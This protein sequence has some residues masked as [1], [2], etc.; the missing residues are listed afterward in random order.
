MQ[1]PVCGGFL[2]ARDVFFSCFF[3][4]VEPHSF[5]SL[6]R[7]PSALL[8]SRR[9]PWV[10]VFDLCVA[11]TIGLYLCCSCSLVAVCV[12]SSYAVDRGGPF[13]GS[14]SFLLLV[15]S[16][17]VPGEGGFPCAQVVVGCGGL[18]F[19][20]VQGCFEAL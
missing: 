7:Y 19:S 16:S 17:W 8:D 13:A 18:T 20:A 9:L 14:G 12:R 4:V 10:L 5:V 3:I 6:S 15:G 2:V 11:V 1:F